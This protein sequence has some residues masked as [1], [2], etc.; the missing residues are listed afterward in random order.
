MYMSVKEVSRTCK[1]TVDS[2]PCESRIFCMNSTL[3]SCARVLRH[4]PLSSCSSFRART[5]YSQS[6]YSS[7]RSFRHGFIVQRAFSTQPP[8]PPKRKL[9]LA[10]RENIYTLPNFLTASRIIACPLI[11]WSILDGQFHLATSLLVYAGLTDLVCCSCFSRECY[12][13]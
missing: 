11:G 13:V 2:N 7:Y 5:S 10:L 4:S 6:L 3:H 12:K 9:P 1:Q 8:E